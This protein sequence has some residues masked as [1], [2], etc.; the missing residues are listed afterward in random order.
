[1]KVKSSWLTSSRFRRLAELIVAITSLPVGI[2]ANEQHVF[3]WRKIGGP[4]DELPELLGILVELKLV[5]F[6]GELLTRTQAGHRIARAVRVVD[7]QPL[8]LSLIR[9][10]CFH[11]QARVLLEFG[12]LDNEGNLHCATRLARTSCPQLIGALESWPEVKVYPEILVPNALLV[13]LDTVWALLPPIEVPKWAAERKAVGTRAEMYTVHY[14]KTLVGG[15][16]IFWVA[17]DSDSLGWDVEDRSVSPYRYI[18]VKGRRDAEVIFYLSD[19]EWK[20]AHE[21]G[22]NYELHFWG[23]IDL[24]ADPAVEYSTLRASGYPIVISNL[25]EELKLRWDATAVSWKITRALDPS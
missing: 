11:D 14:E 24:S 19:N 13:E 17:R 20:K 4:A 8:T 16:F 10:G 25:A 21:L 23:E 6:D 22:A 2:S 1:M 7:L 5:R 9:A 15:S 12:Q 3:L 18:E